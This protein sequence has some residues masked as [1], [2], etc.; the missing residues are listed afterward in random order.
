MVNPAMLDPAA[1]ETLTPPSSGRAPRL[2]PRWYALAQLAGWWLV[3]LCNMVITWA[4]L[5]ITDG[6]VGE[7]LLQHGYDVGHASVLGLLSALVVWGWRRWTP[8]RTG[9]GYLA[10]ACFSATLS[11]LLLRDDLR[12]GAAMLGG[13]ADAVLPEI[14]VALVFSLSVPISAWLGLRLRTGKKGVALL[15]VATLLA[16]GHQWLWPSLY[17]GI[18]SYASWCATLLAAGPLSRGISYMTR[19]TNDRRATTMTRAGLAVV[20]AMA[21]ASVVLPVPPA[22]RS[23]MV[24]IPGSVIAQWSGLPRKLWRDITGANQLTQL[25]AVTPPSLHPSMPPTARAQ[26]PWLPR[27]PIVLLLA[28]D[29]MRADVL[30]KVGDKL[31]VLSSLQRDGVS[32]SHV[33]SPAPSTVASVV[34]FFSG[35]SAS[36]LRWKRKRI[37]RK[38][39]KYPRKDGVPRVPELLHRAQVD[40]GVATHMAGMRP[41]YGLTRGFRSTF[42]VPDRS[43]ASVVKA[44]KRWL[45][46][47]RDGASLQYIHFIDA[48]NPYNLAGTAGSEWDNYIGELGLVDRAIGEMVAHLA[49]QGLTERTIIIITA[50]HGD[51][52]GE[53]NS[54]FHG[55]TVYEEQVRVP[56]I[57]Y[58]PELSPRRVEA[59]VSLLDLAPTLLDLF[60]VAAPG[61]YVG[62]SLLPA[63]MGHPTP[64]RDPIYL[65]SQA[66]YV[67]MVFSDWTKLVIHQG[68]GTALFDLKVDP[69]EAHNI[70]DR[71]PRAQAHQQR[72]RE[73]LLHYG[74][75]PFR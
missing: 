30:I 57:V 24:Q 8:A 52:F 11:Q 71:D 19:A 1:S 63:V 62:Q 28:I 2:A 42:A 7:R 65:D 69:G 44:W 50:D 34:A 48:H 3:A 29:A 61:A 31:P 37:G 72:Y 58:H 26:L 68:G 70:I 36:Q 23:Q 17:P 15:V 10:L 45:P 38:V 46:R 55:S 6:H 74:V 9:H 16:L 53:H 20:T 14:A 64:R 51:A 49:E 32:F 5:G 13:G 67:G 56:L 47:H 43:A 73:Y 35:R 18:H 12:G 27:A 22:V 75:R 66:R 41:A 4:S 39:H 54:R 33:W 21:V 25:R 59:Q 60:D 40:S